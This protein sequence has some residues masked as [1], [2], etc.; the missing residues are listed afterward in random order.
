MKQREEILAGDLSG[1][2]E[3]VVHYYGSEMEVDDEEVQEDDLEYSQSHVPVENDHINKFL[4]LSTTSKKTR[5]LG[6]AEPLVDYSQSQLL[7]LEQHLCNLEDI[8]TRKERVQKEKEEKLIERKLN[9]AKKA[10]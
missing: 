6:R 4:K 3:R 1:S 8:A 5:N 10:E 7:I 2:E 9:K